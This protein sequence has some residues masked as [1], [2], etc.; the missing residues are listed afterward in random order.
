MPES[1]KS[2]QI[3][4]AGKY[5]TLR[6]EYKN[7]IWIAS[8]SYPGTV[9]PAGKYS[10]EEAAFAAAEAKARKILEGHPTITLLNDCPE[11]DPDCKEK[12]R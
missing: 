6:V 9:Y 12:R 5:V 8:F 1:V 4:V 3:E 10:S 7:N 11:D 2:K